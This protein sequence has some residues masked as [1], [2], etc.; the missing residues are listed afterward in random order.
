MPT[1][2]GSF[3]DSRGW[4]LGRCF[5]GLD[6]YRRCSAEVT[7]RPYVPVGT[8]RSLGAQGSWRAGVKPS[9]GVM[10]GRAKRSVVRAA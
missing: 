9:A 7:F 6:R 4:L 1:A 2:Q 3:A 10:A 5:L 8:P